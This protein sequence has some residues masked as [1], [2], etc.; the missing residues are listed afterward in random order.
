MRQ[1]KVVVAT[2]RSALALAQARAWMRAFT[3]ATNVETEELHIVTTG[4]RIV[5][6]ALNEIG[7]KGLFIK[8]IE[9]A[10]LEG[11]ADCAVHSLKDIPASVHPGLRL[12]CIPPREDARDVV[13][14]RT[15]CQFSELPRGARVGTSSL[16]RVVQ[17]RQLRP[18]LEY[19]P[20]RGNV[21]TRLRKCEEGEVDAVVLA[22]AGMNRLAFGHRFT[23]ALEPEVCLPAV[24]Q[25]ALAIELR[26][27]DSELVELLATLNHGETEIAVCAERGV[28][29]AVDG[30]C[31]VPV[32]GYAE[33]RGQSMWLRG[34]L[35]QPAGS[36][37]AR[38]EC[39]VP[40]PTSP[41][42]ATQIG[43]R[44]GQELRVLL[45]AQRSE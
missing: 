36:P 22:M 6:R 14:T 19:V 2:R 24:G 34:F 44:L 8:E 38:S 45:S 4:D 43:E 28:M 37:L 35:A 27:A 30:S 12:G 15:G 32:A 33:R 7:G 39:T 31:Q 10:I 41:E 16:R 42:E 18:D 17:L 11:R 21:D 40:W 26:E 5:D 9:E 1:K 13:T 23:H 29:R 3:A 20:L 25:G